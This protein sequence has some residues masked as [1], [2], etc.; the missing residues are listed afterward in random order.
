MNMDNDTAMTA[1]KNDATARPWARLRTGLTLISILCLA[2]AQNSF[3]A[4]AAGTSPA[5]APDLPLTTIRDFLEGAAA[6]G[7]GRQVRVRGTV[8]HS[9]SDKT[10][11]I[12]EGDAGT[13]VFHKPAKALRVGE[14]V[15]VTGFPSLGT[16]DPTLHYC[17]T[18]VIGSGILPEPKP[19]TATEARSGKYNM[20][21]V[22]VRGSLAPERLRGGWNLVLNPGTGDKAFTADLEA[23]PDLTPFDRLEP[24]SLLELTGV[25]AIRRDTA[26][27]PAS[28][29][30]F[31]RSPG[32]IAVIRTPSWWTPAR[33]WRV[34]GFA[35]LGLALALAWVLTLRRQ[36]RQQTAHIRQMNEDLERRVEERTAEL[37]DANEELDAFSY[38]V[39]HD[40]RAPLRHMS[41]FAAILSQHPSVAQTPDLQKPMDTISNAATQMGR[42]VDDLLAFSRM[43]R[44]PL[45]LQTI[46]FEP[47]VKGA[48]RDLEPDTTGRQIEWKIAPL[49][50][51]RGDVSTLRL[52]WMNLLGNAI[53]YTRQRSPAIIEIGCQAGEREWVFFVRDNGAGFDM[54]YAENLF[55]VFQ[56]LHR[57]D[58]FEGTGVGL[59]H[60]RR[61][62]HR[63]GGRVWAE[64]EPDRGATFY[65]ALP[66]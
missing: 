23:L 39:S 13:Y 34:L 11:F 7:Q 21:V 22:R 8:T 9:I 66:R 33:T 45:S 6:W 14:L 37:T 4:D 58:E 24:G 62:I 56:R 55:G 27:A 16:L 51:V 10:F 17:E 63:H 42:M 43:G 38:S 53:K 61:I 36:I 29:N 18:R 41:G 57:E 65:F 5:D 19:A 48:L 31:I 40:L 44:Q 20:R 28:F 2:G 64:G 12:Q 3:A 26:G 32:D 59:A 49:P 50:E 35:T 25:C 47:L 30:I 15:E 54:R 1:E 52:V 60:V 46:A